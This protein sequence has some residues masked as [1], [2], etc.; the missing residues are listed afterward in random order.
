[1]TIGQRIAQKRKDLELSQEALG[2]SLGVSRQSVYKWEAD[3]ALPE[4]DKLIA[5]SRLFGVTV[6]WLLGVEEPSGDEEQT[7]R[8]PEERGEL[9]ETQLK[10]VQE[11][12]DRYISAQPKPETSPKREDHVSR[13]KMRRWLWCAAALALVVLVCVFGNLFSRLDALRSQYN[14][15]QNSVNYVQSSVNSQIG[16]ITNRVEE[17]LKSQ[18]A[19]TADYGTEII[20]AD[21]AANTVTISAWAT[22][23]TY[24]EGMAAVFQVD[25]GDGA[26][27]YPAKL[28]QGQEFTGAITC[29][30]TDSISVS[31]AFVTG[32]KR[33]TQVLYVY[34]NL[35]TGS[36]PSVDMTGNLDFTWR[37]LEEDGSLVWKDAYAYLDGGRSVS[38]AVNA[39]VGMAE[40]RNIRV[41][42]FRNKQLLA[43]LEP[44]EKPATYHGFEN[45][46][47]Y[48]LSELSVTPE[49][50]DVFCLAAVVTDEFGRETVCEGLPRAMV[51]DGELRH[52][53][54]SE[55]T[56]AGID[57]ENWWNGP[58]DYE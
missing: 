2:E 47:F 32:D 17:V 30:L 24:T 10:L 18:N 48:R 38:D 19:L 22:P 21:L 49:P 29:S 37:N 50:S 45:C 34:S 25:T 46:Q 41:G 53:G 51:Q 57:L 20:S 23:K 42:L 26:V 4:I 15:L 5:M 13:K 6:G 36:I 14:S 1:M 11:I 27:D 35:Y 39:S 55:M 28:G 33:E 43:W 31:V 16:S 56:A 40:V 3:S 7:A 52:V 9:N 58:W 12:V 44:C 54:D 8:A